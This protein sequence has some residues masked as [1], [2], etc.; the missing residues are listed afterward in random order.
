M[1]EPGKKRVLIVDDESHIRLLLKMLLKGLPCEV[2]GEGVNGAEAVSLYKSLK[3]DLMLLDVNMPFKTGTDA[4]G[5]VM[6]ECPEARVVMLTS[7]A[8]METVKRCVTLGAKGYIRKDT[9]PEQI[10][11]LVSN[12]LGV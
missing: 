12:I 2:V 8:D 10:K 7:V 4:L 3:P 9:P 1:T 11:T 6:K 5:D